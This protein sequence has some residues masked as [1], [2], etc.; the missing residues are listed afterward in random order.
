M[1]SKK[2]KCDFCRFWSG[3]GC[4]VTPNSHY[5]KEAN[6]EY[7]QYIKNS[8]TAQPAQKSLRAWDKK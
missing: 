5:C 7:Y 8:K 4:M 3:S 2:V 6:N 1:H